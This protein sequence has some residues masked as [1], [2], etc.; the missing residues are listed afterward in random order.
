MML[1]MLMQVRYH[2]IQSDL[3]R[4]LSVSMFDRLPAMTSSVFDFLKT[5]SEVRC[6]R[7]SSSTAAAAR[8]WLGTMM[9]AAAPSSGICN[10]ALPS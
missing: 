9:H 1:M 5:V 3:P 4:G 6:W 10:A 7:Y 8:A 2:R